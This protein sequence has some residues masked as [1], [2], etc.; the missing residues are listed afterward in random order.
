MLGARGSPLEQLREWL[1]APEP[2][3]V[4]GVLHSSPRVAALEG[5]PRLVDE[6]L[7]RGH[8]ELAV[9]KPE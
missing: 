1:T 2:E 4:L 7:E 3:G 6:E 9:A 5:G 8:I